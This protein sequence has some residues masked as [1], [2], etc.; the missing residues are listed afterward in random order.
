LAF[1]LSSNF[2]KRRWRDISTASLC[3]FC[4][5]YCVLHVCGWNTCNFKLS[6]RQ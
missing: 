6:M 4:V 2:G 3:V 5:R 1:Q